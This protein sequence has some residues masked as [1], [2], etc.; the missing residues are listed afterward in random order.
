[1]HHNDGREGRTKTHEGPVLPA[2]KKPHK[3]PCTRRDYRDYPY[4]FGSPSQNIP[5]TRQQQSVPW[6][7]W[8]ADCM[9]AELRWSKGSIRQSVVD[10]SAS[11]NTQKY[12]T[13]STTHR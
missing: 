9:T 5:L 4:P 7:L 2:Q 6:W 12:A 13:C 8:L 10:Q 3:R 1:M 11:E